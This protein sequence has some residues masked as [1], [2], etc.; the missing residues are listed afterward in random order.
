M[1]LLPNLIG[2][3]IKWYL[4]YNTWKTNITNC[5]TQLLE[6]Y[7]SDFYID[8]YEIIPIPWD[9]IILFNKIWAERERLLPPKKE[10]FTAYHTYSK[11]TKN[12]KLSELWYPKAKKNK[13]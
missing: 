9:N 13:K 11:Y 8:K 10:R 1:I 4:N 12:P 6:S 2:N 3:S 5:H 7:I